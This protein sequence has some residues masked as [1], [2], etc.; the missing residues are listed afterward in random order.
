MNLQLKDFQE[1]AVDDLV[2]H[3]RLAAG[4]VKASPRSL[5]AAWLT[6]PTGSGKTLMATAAIERI[7]DG[8]DQHGRM[9]EAR[10]LWLSDQ[11]ELNEQTRK[12][13]LASSALL[14][15]ADLTVIDAAFDEDVL[16]PRRVYFLNIQKLGKDATLVNPR[17]ARNFTIWETLA[18]TVT[19]HGHE[20]FLIIDEAHRGTVERA[21]AREEAASI[22]QKF[23]KGSPAD[24][25]PPIPILAGISATPERFMRLVGSTARV[26]RPVDVPADDVRASGL[27]KEFIDVHH[28][29]RAAASD[30]TMLAQASKAWHESWQRWARYCKKSGDPLVRPIFV[31]QVADG[32]AKLL[33]KTDLE[34]CVR[35]IRK[36]V[37][38]DAAE[39]LPP[40]AFAH[41]FQEARTEPVGEMELR[42]VAPS[43]IVDD[44]DVRVVF[45]KTSLNTGWDCPSAET[46][47]SFR[48]ALDATS[49]AQLVGRMVRTP[50]ARHIEADDALNAV[51]LYLPH[52]D[53]DNLDR[54]VEKLTGGD[55][56]TSLPIEVRRGEDIIELVKA[57]KSERY[58]EA[59]SALPSYVVP[60]SRRTSEVKRVAKFAFLLVDDEIDP[61]AMDTAHD[62][63]LKVVDDAYLR[64][65]DSPA[66][67][68]W[69]GA[70]A[71]VDVSGR[72]IRLGVAEEGELEDRT[73]PRAVEDVDEQFEEA[74]KGLGEGLHKLWWRRRVAADDAARL[75]A[76]L[77]LIALV[78]D[79]AL[80]IAV[81]DA[82]RETTQAWFKKWK[83]EILELPEGKKA[84]YHE[85]RGLASTPEVTEREPYLDR[86]QATAAERRWKAHVYVDETAGLFPSKFNKWEARVIEEALA[87]QDDV[88]AWLRNPPRKSWSLTIPYWRDG[89]DHP[90][91]PD[92][93]VL[94]RTGKDDLVVDILE[95][96]MTDLADAAAKA[97]GLAKYA[98][99]HR[100]DY[101]RIEFIVVDGETIVRLDLADD[102]WREKVLVFAEGGDASKL[103]MLLK[104]VA[105]EAAPV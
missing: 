22:V 92:F 33:T 38:A 77:E 11:P 2:R 25:L 55:P 59:L 47:M 100:D 87:N 39:L 88:V 105:A 53:A 60:K 51:A 69:L 5:Q 84:E 42:H 56:D 94:R 8:D 26:Q 78:A 18:N 74:G 82:A 54:V 24:G 3:L 68:K 37:G 64:R 48:T 89:E 12:K 93:L 7:L 95:P 10:F 58:F 41:A 44:S 40:R 96:H 71:S 14:G 103:K 97:L 83:K 36:A 28:P 43:E 31:I 49:I 19:R 29:R 101:G 80:G 85:I 91:Y 16:A 52:Y 79:A 20:L 46:M 104:E 67:K 61:R 70:A 35:T 75:T 21:A 99:K 32:T 86:I 17:D 45:F 63:L 30:I 98:A 4:E 57:P 65:K 66:F 90:M 76:K 9:H 72:R 62:R 23:I 15:P 81:E 50:L 6:A 27:L 102:R 13:M 34:L 73:L 1:R